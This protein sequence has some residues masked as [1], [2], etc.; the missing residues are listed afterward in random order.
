[1]MSP[2][3]KDRR[4]Q[5]GTALGLLVFLSATNSVFPHSLAFLPHV[6]LLAFLLTPFYTLNTEFRVIG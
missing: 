4:R 5:S 2:R 3:V 6:H 1:M